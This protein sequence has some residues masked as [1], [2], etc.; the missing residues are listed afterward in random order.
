MRPIENNNVERNKRPKRGKIRK[1]DTRIKATTQQFLLRPSPIRRLRQQA[2]NQAV[3][4]YT[5][6]CLTYEEDRFD[7]FYGV[8]NW[9]GTGLCQPNGVAAFSGILDFG[10][11]CKS[12]VRHERALHSLFS[13]NT[14]GPSRRITHN[15]SRSQALP[16]WSWVGWTGAVKFDRTEPTSGKFYLSYMDQSNIRV[17]GPHKVAGEGWDRLPDP[18]RI[19]PSEGI[20]LHMYAPLFRCK[21]IK[22][23]AN[24][25]SITASDRP[26]EWL[27]TIYLDRASYLA[28]ENNGFHHVILIGEPGDETGGY[29]MLVKRREGSDF[30]ERVEM[31]SHVSNR[32]APKLR[33]SKR[34]HIM[35]V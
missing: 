23:D 33:Y 25:Y 5:A 28:A 19:S 3:E 29:Y 6:R 22:V 30:V 10:E 34:E 7:A 16:S 14:R 24:C 35:I 11:H 31:S 13:W 8:S 26:H 32:D 21:L 20:V 15:K 2:Y 12:G 17:D 27:G 9:F 1:R 4:D 18:C